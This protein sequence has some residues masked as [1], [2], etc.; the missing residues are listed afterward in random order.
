MYP[1]E[2]FYFHL[3]EMFDDHYFMK[4]AL[5]GPKAYDADEV[6]VEAVVV[7]DNKIIARA[8]NL[9]ERL[10]D[11]TAHVKC[12]PSQ[13]RH[14]LNGKYLSDCSFMLHWALCDV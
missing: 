13:Q 12:K 11:V 1:Q 2:W 3:V 5:V 6:P 7:I 4:Q 8:H 9:T 10:N 14:T